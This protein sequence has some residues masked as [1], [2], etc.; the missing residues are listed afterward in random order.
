ME[1]P[2]HHMFHARASKTFDVILISPRHDSFEIELQSYMYLY[3]AVYS[4]ENTFSKS[5]YI[6]IVYTLYTRAFIL[7]S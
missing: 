5:M 4:L 3:C 1:F 6:Q 7:K 2:F